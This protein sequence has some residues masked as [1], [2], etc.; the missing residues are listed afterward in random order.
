MYIKSYKEKNEYLFQL[1]FEAN[2]NLV[3]SLEKQV[4]WMQK[5][6]IRHPEFSFE[7]NGKD[8]VCLIII[9]T[10]GKFKKSFVKYGGINGFIK[11]LTY[12]LKNLAGITSENYLTNKH[13]HINKYIVSWTKHPETGM[14]PVE[15]NPFDNVETIIM[16]SNVGSREIG[17]DY[18]DVIK[19]KFLEPFKI[20][21]NKKE[22]NLSNLPVCIKTILNKPNKTNLEINYLTRFLLSIYSPENVKVVLNMIGEM[23]QFYSCLTDLDNRGCPNCRDLKDYCKNCNKPHPLC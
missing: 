21:K 19:F 23:N 18:L 15:V 6:A 2:G 10:K 17:I 3:N 13:I 22:I 5:I 1:K 20:K 8:L 9:P 4:V 7:F 11:S 14:Y 12:Y 16:K